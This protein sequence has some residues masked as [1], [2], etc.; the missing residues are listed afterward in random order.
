M[1]NNRKKTKEWLQSWG[2]LG[3]QAIKAAMDQPSNNG[4]DSSSYSISDALASAFSWMDSKEGHDF[5]NNHHSEL[6]KKE[7][8]YTIALELGYELSTMEFHMVQSLINEQ[9]VTDDELVFI[10]LYSVGGHIDWEMV[11]NEGNISRPD[12]V[13]LVSKLSLN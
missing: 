2:P 9:E 6:T 11:K 5:W 13:E 4:L 7:R 10:I 8:L 12:L 1:E 3:E